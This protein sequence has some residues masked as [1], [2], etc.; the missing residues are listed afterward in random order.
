MEFVQISFCEGPLKKH[1]EYD[2]LQN[3]NLKIFFGI[4][5]I[6]FNSL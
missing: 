3:Y 1:F 6:R 4:T 5:L 2:E